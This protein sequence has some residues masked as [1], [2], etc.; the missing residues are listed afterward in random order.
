MYAYYVYAYAYSRIAYSRIT[1]SRITY[2]RI[3]YSRIRALRIRALRIRAL[4]IRVLRIRVL[5]IGVYVHGS[6]LPYSICIPLAVCSN[7]TKVMAAITGRRPTEPNST[8]RLGRS[9]VDNDGPTRSSSNLD[10]H[11]G[12]SPFQTIMKK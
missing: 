2:S 6:V 4:R 3:T 1:Y 9:A 11:G 12:S 5:R 8:V 10:D 7:I